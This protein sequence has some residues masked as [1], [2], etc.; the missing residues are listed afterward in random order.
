MIIND[1]TKQE[2]T[3]YLEVLNSGI[4]N[5]LSEGAITKSGLNREKYMFIMQNYSEVYNKY[6]NNELIIG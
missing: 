1:I 2:F 4:Y 5:M 6:I 3:S